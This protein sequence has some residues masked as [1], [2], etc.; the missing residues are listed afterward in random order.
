[1]SLS[2]RVFF[3]PCLS[4]QTCSDPLLRLIS[5]APVAQPIAESLAAQRL[6]CLLPCAVLHRQPS[7]CH[8]R[9]CRAGFLSVLSTPGG[10]QGVFQMLGDTSLHIEGMRAR[11]TRKKEKGVT[12]VTN[13]LKDIGITHI[14]NLPDC[15]SL[16]VPAFC[17]S[18]VVPKSCC[19]TCLDN[20]G[21]HAPDS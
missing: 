8:F 4:I 11:M 19:R 3:Y 17:A 14:F 21:C 16:V 12:S 5:F 6:E 9:Q 10:Q 18:A 1:M 13:R 20:D 2:R 15:N 7:Q